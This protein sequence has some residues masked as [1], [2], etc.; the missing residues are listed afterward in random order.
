MVTV[1]TAVDCVALTNW[2]LSCSFLQRKWC[3]R[4]LGQGICHRDVRKDALFT[5]RHR[6]RRRFLNCCSF[7]LGE[8]G[9]RKKRGH[10][11]QAGVRCV[12][13]FVT[14]PDNRI[15]RCLEGMCVLL[16]WFW[17]RKTKKRRVY[18]SRRT[19][20][21]CRLRHWKATESNARAL[22]VGTAVRS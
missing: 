16:A 9:A 21:K 17:F 19:D 20:L 8:N 3:W 10:R 11:K 7:W 22:E 12:F 14:L 6:A 4:T 18:V 2:T 13:L 15:F 1:V 5:L